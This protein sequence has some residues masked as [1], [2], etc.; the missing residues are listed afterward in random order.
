MIPIPTH[1]KGCIGE[2]SNN[3]PANIPTIIPT[4]C[5]KQFSTDFLKEISIA[6]MAPNIAK[7]V[8]DVEAP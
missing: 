5:V 1:I 7:I 6:L 8:L 2:Y 4:I 3:T